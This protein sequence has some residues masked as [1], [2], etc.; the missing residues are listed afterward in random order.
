[1]KNA[2]RYQLVLVT[3]PDIKTARR[4]ARL[5]LEARAAACANL[6]PKLESHY[7]WQGK[8]QSS[9][10]VLVF[11]KTLKSKLKSLESLILEN[12]PYDTP[13]IISMQLASGTKRYLSWIDTSVK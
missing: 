1:M 11:F 3:T 9:N 13:E 8:I 5:A 7:W 2:S 12:H 6:L 10:E 4:L